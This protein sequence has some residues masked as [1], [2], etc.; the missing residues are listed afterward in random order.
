MFLFWKFLHLPVL[1]VLGCLSVKVCHWRTEIPDYDLP[2]WEQLVQRSCMHIFFS[3]E[4]LKNS[5]HVVAT[6]LQWCHKH[7]VVDIIYNSV[8]SWLQKQCYAVFCPGLFTICQIV[9]LICERSHDSHYDWWQSC[10]CLFALLLLFFILLGI[11]EFDL[12]IFWVHDIS[13]SCCCL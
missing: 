12:G 10:F 1:L 11:W 13:I 5:W 6:G 9:D 2:C 3:V 7:D 8:V 4:Q